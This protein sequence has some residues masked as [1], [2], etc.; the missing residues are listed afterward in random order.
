M[1]TNEHTDVQ[2]ID[3]MPQ[4]KLGLQLECDP[5]NYIDRFVLA[6]GFWEPL[7]V[8]AL[9]AMVRPSDVCVDAGAN[10]GYISIIMARLVGCAGRVLSFEP[11]EQVIRKFRRNVAL[12]QEIRS[13]VELHAVGLGKTAARMFV[14]PDTGVGIGNAGLANCASEGTTNAVQ[15]LTLDSFQL[16]RLDCMK[17]DVEG[18]ELD[19]LMGAAST[20]KRFLPN[21]VFETL[22]MLSPDK[23]KPIE[24]YL[25][26]L[27][28][29]IY[30]INA[31]SGRFEEISYPCYPQDDSYAIHP[32]RIQG[33]AQAQ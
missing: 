1:T 13:C 25:K 6:N 23:H 8:S 14:A 16:S 3:Y 12:N 9:S 4:L 33:S 5:Q 2:V 15:V 22:T 24:D 19:V 18:M 17:V 10:A 31:Q 11:N 28:Y 29:R 27:G 21:I 30:C 20:I 32:D 7:V 26:S